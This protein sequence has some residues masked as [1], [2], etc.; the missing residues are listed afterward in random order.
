MVHQKLQL[1]GRMSE[2]TS[3]VCTAYCQYQT[4]LHCKYEQQV[5][6]VHLFASAHQ[7]N[8]AS[9]DHTSFAGSH[10]DRE[11]RS[12]GVETAA[13]ASFQAERQ[14]ARFLAGCCLSERS[15]VSIQCLRSRPSGAIAQA[16]LAATF[17]AGCC[18]VASSDGSG[19]TDARG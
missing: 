9:S 6:G 10:C 1:L 5:W 18:A 19:R 13:T 8:V 15:Q 7:G 2:E 4:H 17:R 14:H 11:A 16:A 3:H 12:W